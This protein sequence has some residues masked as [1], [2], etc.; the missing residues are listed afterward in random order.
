M[1]MFLAVQRAMC[2]NTVHDHV[3]LMPNPCRYAKIGGLF[4]ACESTDLL[5][6]FIGMGKMFFKYIPRKV[7]LRA[8]MT[9][10]QETALER[11]ET[12]DS[13]SS[14]RKPVSQQR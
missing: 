11:F 6:L 14:S 3:A 5:R 7:R 12:G 8:P 9:I 13:N 1:L 2:G 4:T 10:S